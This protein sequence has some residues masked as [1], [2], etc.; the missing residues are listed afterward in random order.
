[1]TL[2]KGERRRGGGVGGWGEREEEEEEGSWS[3]GLNIYVK[4]AT[5]GARAANLFAKQVLPRFCRPEPIEEG[6]GHRMLK[7][8]V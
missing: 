7:E 5:N 4:F 2:R 8:G 6:S 1:M 3:Q